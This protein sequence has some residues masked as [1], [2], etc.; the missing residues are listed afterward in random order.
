MR[1]LCIFTVVLAVSAGSSLA[2]D[3]KPDQLKKMYDESVGQLQA[4]QTRINELAMENEKLNARLA[5]VQK[6]LD[7]ARANELAFAEKTYQWRATHAAWEQFLKRYP[8]LL[9]QWQAF[10][11]QDLLSPSSLPTWMESGGAVSSATK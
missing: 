3:I 11:K 6:Q 7:A 8:A 9:G 10:L 4:A 1:W 5:D 2:D